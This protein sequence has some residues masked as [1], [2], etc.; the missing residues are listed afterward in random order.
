[1]VNELVHGFGEGFECEASDPGRDHESENEDNQSS[2]CE[3]VSV[4]DCAHG[5]VPAE[6]GDA[7]KRDWGQHLRKE[8][9]N[10]RRV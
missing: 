1:M 7:E 4:S 2:D 9:R 6:H 10:H 5:P 3:E 8:F